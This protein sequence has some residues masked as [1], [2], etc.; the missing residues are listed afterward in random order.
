MEPLPPQDRDFK[1][2]AMDWEARGKVEDGTYSVQDQRHLWKNLASYIPVPAPVVA[3]PHQPASPTRIS[4]TQSNLDSHPRS[5]PARRD[6]Y[7]DLAGSAHASVLERRSSPPAYQAGGAKGGSVFRVEKESEDRTSARFRDSVS[8]LAKGDGTK[9]RYF[10]YHSKSRRSELYIPKSWEYRMLRISTVVAMGHA[11]CRILKKTFTLQGSGGGPVGHR[12]LVSPTDELT[13]PSRCWRRI[14]EKE[15]MGSSLLSQLARKALLPR[16]IFAPVLRAESC[17]KCPR[18]HVDRRTAEPA[19]RPLCSTGE[20]HRL[21]V[22]LK[23]RRGR[24]SVPRAM[25]RAAKYWFDYDANTG[26]LRTSPICPTAGGVLEKKKKKDPEIITGIS[27]P[28]P[29]PNSKGSSS[30][31]NY[32]IPPT[33]QKQQRKSQRQ[34]L[35]TYP[36]GL[37][38]DSTQPSLTATTTVQAQVSQPE[39]RKFSS[40]YTNQNQGRAKLLGPLD[41]PT[42]AALVFLN[43]KAVIQLVVVML[44]LVLVILAVLQSKYPVWPGRRR[45]TTTLHYD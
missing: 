34:R 40:N 21:A 41:H 7:L 23:W 33:L 10:H 26:R 15:T 42:A 19:L 20:D 2:T 25:F 43:S 45:T 4:T 30:R 27:Y 8:G 37:Q 5:P 9:Y 17:I 28:Y 3:S 29:N 38:P 39:V 12:S 13:S 6:L 32:Y 24:E 18:G 22:S 1:S 35:R 16:A 11:P 14:R 44:L 36:P 31:Y